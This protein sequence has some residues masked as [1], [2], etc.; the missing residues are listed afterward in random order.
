MGLI[1]LRCQLRFGSSIE[2]RLVRSLIA[3]SG[4]VVSPRCR[5]AAAAEYSQGQ[6]RG[7]AGE[8]EGNKPGPKMFRYTK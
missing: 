3:I 2:S 7:Y 8:E 4:V 6:G 5:Q 1:G